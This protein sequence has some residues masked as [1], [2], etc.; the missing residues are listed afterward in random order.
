MYVCFRR[1][2]TPNDLLRHL[3]QPVGICK[4]RMFTTSAR[5]ELLYNAK[6]PPD[7]GPFFSS[8]LPLI[9][10]TYRESHQDEYNAV[11]TFSIF[12]VTLN[13]R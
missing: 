13:I 6:C 3:L 4:S 9:N 7:P 5:F 8:L 2:F 12:H 1:G 10:T 11:V